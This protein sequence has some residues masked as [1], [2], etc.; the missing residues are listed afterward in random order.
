MAALDDGSGAGVRGVNL[1]LTQDS[2]GGAGQGDTGTVSI[3]APDESDLACDESTRET[4]FFE[5]CTDENLRRETRCALKKALGFEKK[6][7]TDIQAQK[8]AMA[9]SRVATIKRVQA[10]GNAT[11]VDIEVLQEQRKREDTST[12]ETARHQ[13]QALMLREKGMQNELQAF[14]ENL[15]SERDTKQ[16]VRGRIRKDE[17]YKEVDNKKAGKYGV[18]G[19]T[20]GCKPTVVTAS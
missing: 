8:A 2:Q 10:P 14:E 19:G 17:M 13:E 11:L 16:S 6:G 20:S 1:T 7:E 3:T 5:Y 15:K 9:S 18:F 4:H 12:A